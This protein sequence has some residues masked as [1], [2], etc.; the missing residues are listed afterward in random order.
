MTLRHICHNLHLPTDL[1]M[2]LLIGVESKETHLLNTA[3]SNLSRKKVVKRLM[4]VRGRKRVT[5]REMLLEMHQNWRKEGLAASRA[6][7]AVLH[8]EMHAIFII[9]KYITSL[10]FGIYSLLTVLKSDHTSEYY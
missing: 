7:E 2:F 4:E 1:K 8:E 5:K 3:I 6:N 9:P 10:V